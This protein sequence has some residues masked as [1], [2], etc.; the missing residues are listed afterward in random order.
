MC[1]DCNSINKL[2]FNNYCEPCYKIKLKSS[3]TRERNDIFKTRLYDY[4][5]KAKC[6]NFI[7]NLDDETALLFM[8]Q[9][10]FYCNEKNKS[11]K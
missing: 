10:C 7:W 11:Y 4:R 2:L 6:K 9:N 3:R 5:K 8:K 1:Y